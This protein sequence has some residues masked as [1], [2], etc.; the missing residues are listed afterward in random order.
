MSDRKPWVLVLEPPGDACNRLEAMISSQGFKAEMISEGALPEP[1]GNREGPLAVFVNLPSHASQLDEVRRRYADSSV[2]VTLPSKTRVPLEAA[3]KA[4]A[5]AFCLRPYQREAVGAALLCAERLRMRMTL[6]NPGSGSALPQEAS[7]H[8]SAILDSD[9][10]GFDAE[11]GFYRVGLF[12]RLL[13]R[14]LVRGKRYGGDLALCLVS[15]DYGGSDK[16]A[17]PAEVAEGLAV[18]V[19]HA[20]SGVIRKLDLAMRSGPAEYLLVLPHT[21]AKGAELLGRRLQRRIHRVIYREGGMAICPRA[22]VGIASQAQSAFS[23]ATFARMLRKAKTALRAAQLK[24][25]SRLVV[26]A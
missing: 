2:V 10:G 1:D 19:A 17:V 6:G 25:G 15:L 8:H 16:S 21:N 24:G 14:E 23:G 20:V 11:T 26:R 3:R 9:G 13:E 18:A 12:K 22:S 4:G 5:D 7:P